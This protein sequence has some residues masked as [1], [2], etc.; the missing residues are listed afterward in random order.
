[1]LQLVGYGATGWWTLPA[2]D[3]DQP[4]VLDSPEWFMAVSE[5]IDDAAMSSKSTR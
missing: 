2:T 3:G 5:Q 1:V 4:G